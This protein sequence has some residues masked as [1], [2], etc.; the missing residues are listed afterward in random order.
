[1]NIA[2]KSCTPVISDHWNMGLHYSEVNWL[3][4]IYFRELDPAPQSLESSSNQQR[5][6]QIILEVSLP[7]F[8]NIFDNFCV[9][10]CINV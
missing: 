6:K 10:R 8:S 9:L 3:M 7:V 5:N 2:V 1:M 4:N